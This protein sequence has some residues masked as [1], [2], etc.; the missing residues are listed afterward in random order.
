MH[1]KYVGI[2]QVTENRIN[3]TYTF[4]FYYLPL[5]WPEHPAW[6]ILFSNISSYLIYYLEFSKMVDSLCHLA[7]VKSL[8]NSAI[9]CLR[10][11]RTCLPAIIYT[12]VF[13]G[14]TIGQVSCVQYKRRKEV[15]SAHFCTDYFFIF[16]FYELLPLCH[17]MLLWSKLIWTKSL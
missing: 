11:R 12:P 2:H 7:N 4:Q 17:I 3:K 10:V 1:G 15:F 6:E 8:T 13:R 16:H 9:L 5:G 14:H